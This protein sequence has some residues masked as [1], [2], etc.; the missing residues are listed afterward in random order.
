M[1]AS[2]IL[3]FLYVLIYTWILPGIVSM[4][5]VSLA[6][7]VSLNKN[8]RTRSEDVRG[9]PRDHRFLVAIPAHNEQA[10]VAETVRS[11]LGIDYPRNCF[12]VLVI[13]DNCTDTTATRAHEAGARVL[14]RFDPASK[15]KGHAIE[16]LIG[17]LEQS[18]EFGSLDALVVIDADSTVDSGLLNHFS[19]GLDR[20]SDWMQCYDCVGNADQSWRTR[21]MA[22]GF[23]LFNG[24]ALAGRQALGLSAGLRGNG[25]CLSTAGLRR[26]PWKAHGLVEDLE[27]SWNVR[28]SGGRIDF[29]KDTTVFATMLSEG[30][31]P[32]AGQRRRWEFGRADVRRKMFG[33]LVRSPHLGW[34]QKV[35]DVVELTAPPIGQIAAVYLILTALAAFAIPGMISHREYLALALIGVLHLIATS[36][37]AIYALSPFF[38]SL[39]PWR[40]IFSLVYFP[41]YICWKLVIL[42]QGGPDR[43]I[44]TERESHPPRALRS[45]VGQFAD[46]NTDSA[47]KWVV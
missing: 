40:F 36:A 45:Q 13:A 22:H 31:S 11:C 23:S 2:M 15:S 34:R 7:I 5:V 6:A 27:Y 25:M 41:Y 42:A 18:G 24:I 3:D 14:E 37:L 4:L 17:R 28:I 35:A 38:T 44:P 30:G 8:R 29:I 43:W 1:H 9:G 10:N 39:L 20:G 33:P 16:F 32:L 47:S 46:G 12:E 26:V 21:M 19:W